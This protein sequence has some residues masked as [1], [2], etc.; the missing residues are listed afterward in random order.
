M[1]DAQFQWFISESRISVEKRGSAT[2]AY[3]H[4]VTAA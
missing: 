2:I 1:S 4:V 3:R